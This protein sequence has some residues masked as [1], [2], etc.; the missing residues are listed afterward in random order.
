MPN[1]IKNFKDAYKYFKKGKEATVEIQVDGGINETTAKIC[2]E[3]GSTTLISGSYLFNAADMK[4]AV[5]LLKE[6]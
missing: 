1:K 5:A 6:V 4:S 2:V 3:A